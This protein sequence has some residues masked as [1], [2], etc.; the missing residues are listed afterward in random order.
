MKRLLIVCPLFPPANGADCHRARVLAPCLPNFGWQAEV[1]AVNP[2]HLAVP[3][4]TW[5]ADGVGHV[6]IHRAEAL[7]LKWTKIPGLGTLSHRAKPFVKRLGS[8]L[9]SERHFDMV[10]FSSLVY[11]FN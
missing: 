11:N 7:S 1:L 5:L 3:R 4:D 9:L 10:Y 8:T 2:E 6:P